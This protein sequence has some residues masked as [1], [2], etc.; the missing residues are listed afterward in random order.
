M[1]E[2]KNKQAAQKSIAIIDECMQREIVTPVHP[3]RYSEQGVQERLEQIEA[4]GIKQQMDMDRKFSES[5]TKAQ[6]RSSNDGIVVS[7]L[8]SMFTRK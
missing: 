6:N 4:D 7:V 3:K 1:D 8:K 2:Q 5:I